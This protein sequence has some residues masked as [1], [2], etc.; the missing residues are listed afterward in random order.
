MKHAPLGSK[1][2]FLPEQALIGVTLFK[3]LTGLSPT[4]TEMF[5]WMM[6]MTLSIEV[7]IV[8]VC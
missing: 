8:V 5:V 4:F 3:R 7:Y 6:Y 1:Y 2:S